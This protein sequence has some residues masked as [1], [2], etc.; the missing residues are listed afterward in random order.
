[1]YPR[2]ERA[3]TQPFYLLYATDQL[4]IG[5]VAERIIMKPDALTYH[6][7]QASASNHEWLWK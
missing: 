2:K 1:V 7:Q 5:I 6:N 3:H 4:V